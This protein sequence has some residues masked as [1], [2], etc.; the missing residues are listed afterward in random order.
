MRVPVLPSWT[1][2][3]SCPI[4]LASSSYPLTKYLTYSQFSQPYQSFLAAISLDRE[5]SSYHEAVSDSRW[6]AAMDLEFAALESNHTWDMVSL[7]TII[8][9]EFGRSELATCSTISATLS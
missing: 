5:P 3:Y 2:F 1:E 8:P 7:P 6:K 9:F 4:N